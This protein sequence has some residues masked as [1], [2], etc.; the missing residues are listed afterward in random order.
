MAN[1]QS[2]TA[3]LVY[4]DPMFVSRHHVGPPPR[5]AFRAILRCCAC[6]GTGSCPAHDVADFM[7]ELERDGCPECGEGPVERIGASDAG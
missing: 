3:G 6:G 7:A 5:S 1:E 4:L 2:G